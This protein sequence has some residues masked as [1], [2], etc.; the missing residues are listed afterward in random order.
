MASMPTFSTNI[1]NIPD[2]DDIDTS[3]EA[4]RVLG[5]HVTRNEKRSSALVQPFVKT[6]PMPSVEFNFKESS[7][8]ARLAISLCSALGI[9]ASCRALGTLPKRSMVQLTGRLALRGI[10]FTSFSLPFDI[11]GRLEAGEF[12]FSGEEGSQSISS[13]MMFLPCLLGDS[14][15]KLSSP[16]ADSSFID[17]TKDSLEKFGIRI[18]EREDGFFVPGRQFYQSP[19]E[20]SVENDWGLASMWITAAAACGANNP[21]VRVYNLPKNSHQ[22][23]RNLTPLLSM[24]TCDF[25]DINIDTSLMPNL[26]TLFC[27]L[28]IVK[29]ATVRISGVPQLKLKE[30]NRLKAMASIAETL[31]QKARLSEDGITIIGNGSPSYEENTVVDCQGDPWVFMSMVLSSATM[32]RPLILSDEHGADKIYR[33]FLSDYKKLGGDFEII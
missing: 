27:S 30:T 4:L 1:S 31:G 32:E 7:T 20:I 25:K 17:I 26:T 9:K 22:H 3:I 21:G 6:T 5:C 11:S 16:S 14:T 10:T 13:L 18:E 2:C 28:A 19:S 15:I 24:L 29:G 8:T 33:G 12:V 23:Y